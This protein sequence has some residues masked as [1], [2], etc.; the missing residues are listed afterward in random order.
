MLGVMKKLL[1]ARIYSKYSCTSKLSGRHISLIDSR[2]N[3]LR[4]YCPSEFARRPRT[5]DLCSKYKATE[6]RQFLLYTGSIVTY[7]LLNDEL[8][9]LLIVQASYS[10]IVLLG[11]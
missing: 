5:L 7:G 3:I 4:K 1:S 11:F 8:Y 9:K 10:Y 2:L 6:F